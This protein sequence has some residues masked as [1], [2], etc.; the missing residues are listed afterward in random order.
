MDEIDAS[1]LK[2]PS[3]PL[4]L[5]IITFR[6]AKKHCITF[7]ASDERSLATDHHASDT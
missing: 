2:G 7:H 4:I 1:Y 3:I 5:N 6:S